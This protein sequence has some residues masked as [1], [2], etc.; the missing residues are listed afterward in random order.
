VG[1]VTSTCSSRL[2][3]FKVLLS[4]CP[5]TFLQYGVL[6]ACYSFRICEGNFLPTPSSGVFHTSATVGNLAHPKLAGGSHQT[7][8]LL[9]ACL[10][11]L[12]G[13]LP[14][15]LQT[16]RCRA[17]FAMCLFQFFVYYSGFFFFVGQR[18]VCPGVYPGLSQEW[19]WWYHVLLICSP[20][21]LRLLN[22]LGAGVWWHGIPP[23]FSV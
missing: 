2:Y 16:S 19:L 6:P 22:M 23:G 5:S 12:R 17:L 18:S 3:L 11:S 1:A 4:A 13:C 15:L 9:L 14:L 20:V 8:L 10:F 7:C 21:G